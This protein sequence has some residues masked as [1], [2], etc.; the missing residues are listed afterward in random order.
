MKNTFKK[1]VFLLMLFNLASCFSGVLIAQPRGEDEDGCNY[2]GPHFNIN[3]IDLGDEILTVIHNLDGTVIRYFS[4]KNDTDYEDEYDFG[5]D[6]FDWDDFNLNNGGTNTGGNGSAGGSN[7]SNC[8]IVKGVNAVKSGGTWENYAKAMGWT[9][10]GYSGKITP[11]QEFLLTDT[12]NNKSFYGL[13]CNPALLEGF[14]KALDVVYQCNNG[15]GV[16]NLN[17]SQIDKLLDFFVIP[18]QVSAATAKES[19]KLLNCYFSKTIGTNFADCVFPPNQIAASSNALAFV[20]D[21]YV[22]KNPLDKN[23]IDKHGCEL[24]S[25]I[26][27]LG[28]SSS[29]L[30]EYVKHPDAFKDIIKFS[31]TEEDAKIANYIAITGYDSCLSQ[32]QLNELSKIVQK[33]IDPTIPAYIIWYIVQMEYIRLGQEYPT[34]SEFDKWYNAWS[35]ITHITLDITGFVPLLGEVADITNGIIYSIEGNPTNACFS[36]AAAIPIAGWASTGVKYAVK[37]LKTIGQSGRTYKLT[38]K[39]INNIVSFGESNALRAQ[40]RLILQTAKGY[41]AHHVIPLAL[42]GHDVIQAAARSKYAFH[43]NEFYNGIN[44]STLYHSG[45]HPNYS[46]RVADALDKI[47]TD[48]PKLNPEACFQKVQDLLQEIRTAIINNPTTNIDNIVW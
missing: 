11:L 47:R 34:M 4:P 20:L 29:A 25:K 44:I 28:L 45:N 31:C 26:E 18:N 17:G 6:I 1:Y 12:K 36:F 46:K 16:V 35:N 2:F 27:C 5:D 39:I 22:K 40:L 8:T 7:G 38:Y 41:A 30:E 42:S 14:L 33:D 13:L 9:N 3:E 15:G 37:T 32:E 10:F 48:N 21:E 24:I 23:W 19:T 43:I